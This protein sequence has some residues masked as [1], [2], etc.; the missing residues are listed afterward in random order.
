MEGLASLSPRLLMFTL[1]VNSL[2]LLSR[3]F[4]GE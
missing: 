4:A 1:K 3:F 2:V